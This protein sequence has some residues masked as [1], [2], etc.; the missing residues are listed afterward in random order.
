MSKIKY[1]YVQLYVDMDK[2]KV[3]ELNDPRG[4]TLILFLVC[5]D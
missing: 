5:V 2:V 4:Y 1:V 3:G